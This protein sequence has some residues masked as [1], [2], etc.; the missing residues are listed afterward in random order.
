MNKNITEAYLKNTQVI[1]EMNKKDVKKSLPRILVS[2]LCFC[3]SEFYLSCSSKVQLPSAFPPSL[4]RFDVMKPVSLT[5]SL[6]LSLALTH[7]HTHK[8][9]GARKKTVFAFQGFLMQNKRG[10]SK[11]IS[12]GS[13]GEGR[14]RTG[15]RKAKAEG[16]L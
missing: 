14:G 1:K 15:G 10:K 12:V 11:K 2:F 9:T 4:P 5:L 8:N 13:E 16:E 6:S 7:T 3:D